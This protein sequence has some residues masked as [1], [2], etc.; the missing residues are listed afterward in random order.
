METGNS[1]NNNNALPKQERV[2]GES[3]MAGNIL[4]SNPNLKKLQVDHLYHIG[5]DNSGKD[6][7]K[8]FGDVRLVVVGGCA[9]RMTDFVRVL[10]E[11]MRLC[12]VE[13]NDDALVDLS[14]E[15]GRYC[16]FKVNHVLV[17]NHGMGAGSVS[18]LIH[19]LLKLLSYA[20]AKNVSFVR[21]GTCGGLDVEPGTIC[22]TDSAMGPDGE[23]GYEFFQC[24][25]KIRYPANANR[26]LNELL[27]STC[28]KFNRTYK[29]GNTVTS[30]DFYES[31]GRL[32]G[33]FCEYSEAAKLGWLADLSENRGAINCEMEAAIFL[34]LCQ[35][36]G[37]SA[38]VACVALLNR[39]HGDQVTTEGAAEGAIAVKALREI[40]LDICLSN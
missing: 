32:D 36:A 27:A 2:K 3:E 4:L 15:R 29:I 28:A 25:K 14:E 31:Q 9:K 38:A 26:E 5:L 7:E 21:M 33:A 35:R 22:L 8:R 18:I 6:L 20:K 39:L 23:R 17:A 12:D 1:S 13:V 30:P 24:G 19:E 40:L 11:K 37:V 34:S 10:V 16:L